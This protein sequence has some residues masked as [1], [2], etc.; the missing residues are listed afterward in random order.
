MSTT[1]REVIESADYDLSTKT[2]ASWLLA[3]QGTFAEL[4]EQAE[5]TIDRE[6]ECDHENTSTEIVENTA[7]YEYNQ[8]IGNTSYPLTQTEVTVC[9]DC[10]AIQDAEGNW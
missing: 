5:E 1:I 7:E 9:D 3:Q 6:D 2:D 8:G 10:G 4:V